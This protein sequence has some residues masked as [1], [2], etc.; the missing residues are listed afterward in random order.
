MAG[1]PEPSNPILGVILAGGA[2]RR[3]GGGDKGLADL[4]GEPMLAHVIRRLRPQAATLILNA[5]GD[6]SRFDGFGLP[7]VPDLDERALGPMSGLLAAMDFAIRKM[8]SCRAI[9]TVTTDVPFLPPDLIARLQTE[10]RGG[11]AIATSAGRRH[12]TIALWPLS[13][14]PE[15]AAAL[16]AN[17]L[18]VNRFAARNSAI[19]VAF[20][21]S[22]TGGALID[23]FFN[24]NT[25]D[26]LA[27]ARHLI[28]HQ[29]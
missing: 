5:N 18:S 20:Q 10:G 15:V 11:P 19:E 22:E 28:E 26:D 13:L 23:P 14:K 9:A 17:E 3:M 12:P 6:A 25:P 16:D 4:G 21:F 29:T 1:A 7:V 24:A 27:A 2:A 8:P